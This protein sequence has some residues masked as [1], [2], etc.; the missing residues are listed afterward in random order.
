[1][2]MRMRASENVRQH[3]FTIS[4]LVYCTASLSVFN[5]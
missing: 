4:I 5:L 1:M 3:T 2:K